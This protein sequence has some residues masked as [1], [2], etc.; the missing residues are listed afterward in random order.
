MSEEIAEFYQEKKNQ[1]EVDQFRS[2][3]RI[4]LTEHWDAYVNDLSIL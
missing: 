1:Q 3:H 2:T 4:I